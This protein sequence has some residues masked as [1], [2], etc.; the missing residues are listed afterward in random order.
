GRALPS[1]TAANPAFP[2]VVP[3]L[4]F[5]GYEAPFTWNT[6]SPRAGFTYALDGSRKTV[7]RASYSRFAG[8]LESGTV[9]YMNPSSNAGVAVYRWNDSNGDHLAS[10]DEVLLN[11]F[12]AAAN[13]FNP[14]NP[15]AVTSSNRIDPDLRAPVTQSMV[16]GVDRELA[17]NLSV[18]A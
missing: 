18:G 17:A 3:G 7:A 8:Q 2:S 14:A 1:L 13:G 11:Q 16:A 10:A 6:I 15:T 12:V 5:A 4:D 9:G